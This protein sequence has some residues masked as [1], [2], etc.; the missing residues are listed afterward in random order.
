MSQNSDLNYAVL[1]CEIM[2]KWQL[3]EFYL[4]KTE[5]REKWAQIDQLRREWSKSYDE[6][7]LDKK[8][9][10]KEKTVDQLIKVLRGIL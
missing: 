1:N 10:L 4:I 6:H 8:K 3:V 5:Q 9:T 2:I 7:W